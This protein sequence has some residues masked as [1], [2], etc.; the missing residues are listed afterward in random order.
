M[1]G[2]STSGIGPRASARARWGR[3]LCLFGLT[4]LVLTLHSPAVEPDDGRYRAIG[5]AGG[6]IVP[7]FG[8]GERLTFDVKYGFISA[9]TA[10]MA[11]PEFVE[12]Q[13]YLCYHIVSLAVSNRF[14]AVFFPVRDL[15]ESCLDV[16]ELVSRRF[17]KHLREGDFRAD[18]VAILDH[19]RHLAVYPKDG[20]VV[21]IPQ[22][23]QDILSSLYYVRTVPLEVGSSVFIE[24]HADRKNYPLEIRVLR[25]ESVSVPAGR[26]DCV[27]VEPLMQ[28]TGIF[29]HQG[30]LTI[31]MTDDE[32]RIPVMMRSKVMIGSI[33]AVLT[34]AVLAG[35]ETF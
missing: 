23:A 31:Y 25:K 10:V 27:V 30:R 1:A 9:G 5:P 3:T 8:V 33:S 4:V 32:R 14:F 7:P 24:N 2:G 16:R 11:I 34:K 18:D 20:R 17:E 6:C 12:E 26:F 28:A 19:D 13:G 21:E 29:K 15:A 35:G 22:M